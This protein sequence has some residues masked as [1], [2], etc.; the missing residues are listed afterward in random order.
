[1]ANE[2]NRFD[3]KKIDDQELAKREALKKEEQYAAFAR[4]D[5][6]SAEAEEREL[7]TER[8]R[9]KGMTA[10]TIGVT[11][12]AGAV[13]MASVYAG[14]TLG[15]KLKAVFVLLKV[16]DWG[17]I[18]RNEFSRELNDAHIPGAEFFAKDPAAFISCL[19]ND[20][21]ISEA[22]LDTDE[23]AVYSSDELDFEETDRESDDDLR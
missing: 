3:E 14:L 12:G 18:D 17:H 13:G 20:A 15:D 4:R 10:A 21:Q 9:S 1:M 11:A 23:R 16:A 8:K 5:A 6:V 19:T 22:T 7:Q 2:Q